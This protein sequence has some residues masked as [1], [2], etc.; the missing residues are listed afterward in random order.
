M[1]RF[2]LLLLLAFTA[3]AAA[4]AEPEAEVKAAI[5][6][7]FEAFHDR[8]TTRIREML[9]ADMILQSVGLSREGEV[10][11]RKEA[12]G[13]FLASL[14]GI[15]DSVAIEERLLEYHIQV[16]GP[17]AHAWTPYAFYLRGGFSHCGV[18]SFHFVRMDGRWRMVSLIDTRR[19]EGC[20]TG[21][22][23]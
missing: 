18:N 19:R 3:G 10:V 12:A 16:D 23:G 6:A 17:M 20:E 9:A 8:D 1:K 22:E 5:D 7:F 14:A 13:D 4:Q 11:L 21:G 15:P 2:L